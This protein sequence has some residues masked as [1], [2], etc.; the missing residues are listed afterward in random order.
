VGQVSF[1]LS[2]IVATTGVSGTM[3]LGSVTATGGATALPVGVFA[4]G[5]VGFANVWGQVDDEQDANWQNIDDTQLS[6]WVDVSDTQIADWQ[7][8]AA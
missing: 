8:V 6:P 1:S 7:E 4:A 3:R 2:I 5:A